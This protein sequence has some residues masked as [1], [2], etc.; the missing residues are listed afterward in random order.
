LYVANQ[1][2]FIHESLISARS[3]KRFTKYPCALVTTEAAVGQFDVSV[4]DQIC[5]VS[6]LQ[7]YTY[8]AKI[9]GLL[10]TPF[11]K[12]IFLD[13]DTFICTDIDEL[14]D[15]TD[16]VDIATTQEPKKHTSTL[17]DIQYKNIF[18]EFN[19]GVIVIRKNPTTL[20]LLHDWLEVCRSHGLRV[21]MPGLREAIL[22]NLNDI[23]FSILP[24]EYNCH[25]FQ[26]MVA[27]YG[28]VKV[29]HER[30]GNN[31]RT[32]TPYFQSFEWMERFSQRVNKITYKRIYIPGL[33]IIPYNWNIQ[34][35]L[36]KIKK[37]VGLK[38][39]SKRYYYMRGK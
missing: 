13:C 22:K 26:T 39:T 3:L 10:N 4:F 21:D 23:K 24:E 36:F 28:Q 30:L 31:W 20:K 16:I 8:L 25:G 29:I 6:K 18:P 12:T 35:M 32:L 15:L 9:I 7:N 5:Y 1:E 19:S 11:E 34:S 33:G 14:F 17:P 27:L 38:L 2:K 37:L